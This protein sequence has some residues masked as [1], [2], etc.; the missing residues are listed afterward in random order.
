MTRRDPVQGDVA[1]N[2]AGAAVPP[3][4]C[5]SCVTHVLSPCLPRAAV[6][7]APD[8]FGECSQPDVPNGDRAFAATQFELKPETAL[9]RRLVTAKSR[10]AGRRRKRSEDGSVSGTTTRFNARLC[11]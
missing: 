9:S 2:P 5:H 1:A 11:Q 6:G 3:M 4:S 8:A 10:N 7:V